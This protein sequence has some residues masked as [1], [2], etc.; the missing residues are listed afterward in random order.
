MALNRVWRAAQ[1]VN[2]SRTVQETFRIDS[3]IAQAFPFDEKG[4]TGLRVVVALPAGAGGNA[5]EALFRVC[6]QVR[7]VAPS[8]ALS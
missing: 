2:K 4:L 3:F 7:G 8:I 6:L 1:V 5:S